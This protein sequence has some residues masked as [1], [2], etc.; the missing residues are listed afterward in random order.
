MSR[1]PEGSSGLCPELH[2]CALDS[3][4]LKRDTRRADLGASCMPTAAV[5]G[6]HGSPRGAGAAA[7]LCLRG[8]VQISPR[9]VLTSHQG[10]TFSCHRTEL[11]QE[12]REQGFKYRVGFK[13]I[14][15]FGK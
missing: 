13:L 2:R 12:T 3:E 4:K 10:R 8:L 11:A 7:S 15:T 9:T 1:D 6:P 5:P 14:E